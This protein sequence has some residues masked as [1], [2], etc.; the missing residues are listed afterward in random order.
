MISHC[1]PDAA[2]V[3]AASWA[4][5]TIRPRATMVTSPPSRTT[6]ASPKGMLYSSAGTSAFVSYSAL[7]SQKITGSSSRMA[8]TIRPLA[9]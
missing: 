4:M 9:S 3:S 7:C 6:L 5:E 8:W 2:S 1:T